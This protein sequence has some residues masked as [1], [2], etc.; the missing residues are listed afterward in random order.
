MSTLSG[1]LFDVYPSGDGMLVWLLDEDGRMHALHDDAFVPRLYVRGPENQLAGLTRLLRGRR[2]PVY[3][4]TH[5]TPRSVPRP[6]PGGARDRRARPR[7][8]AGGAALGGRGPPRPDLLRRRHPAAAALRPGARGLPRR[9][10][11]GGARRRPPAPPRNPRHPLGD[12]LPASAAAGDEPASGRHSRRPQRPG[13][14]PGPRRG[15]LRIAPGLCRPDRR[16]RRTQVT[17]PRRHGRRLLLGVRHL[18]ER[19]DPD[20]L[21]TAYG[22]SY[23]LPRLLHLSQPLRRARCRSTATPARPWATRR[24][25]PTS[26][27]AASS[28]ATNNTCSSAAGT[29]TATTPSWPTTT[30]WTA[31]SRSPASPVCRSRPSPASPPAPASAPCRSPPPGAAA[32]SSRGRNASPNR[33]RP[34]SNC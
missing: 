20:L 13:A 34:A 1:W 3:A 27:T 16:G 18:L 21:V 4:A 12:R 9:L 31:R 6:R 15:R 17:F 23:L 32:C 5:R 7:P 19:H 33:S 25:T 30:G 14:P 26:P 24:P 29:S 10:L 11:S 22:D 8:A 28:S 2:A